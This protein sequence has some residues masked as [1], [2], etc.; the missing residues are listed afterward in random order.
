MSTKSKKQK[1]S[2]DVFA[3]V[4]VCKKKTYQIDKS[5]NMQQSFHTIM[6]LE[7]IPKPCKV[8]T[9]RCLSNVFSNEK[10]NKETIKEYFRHLSSMLWTMEH[11]EEQFSWQLLG[12]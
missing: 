7:L 5:L 10:F 2:W 11:K 4:P 8:V 1:T 6:F 3:A 9:C 12:R